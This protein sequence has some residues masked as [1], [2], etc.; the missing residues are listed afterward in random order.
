VDDSEPEKNRFYQ[1]LR[2]KKKF[3]RYRNNR[4]KS[5]ALVLEALTKK[6]DAIEEEDS[7]LEETR[8]E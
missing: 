7:D 4:G 8:R 1:K 2:S 5:N 6:I 3:G